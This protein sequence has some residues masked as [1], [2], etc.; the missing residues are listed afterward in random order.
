MNQMQVR[1]E[2]IKTNTHLL[3]FYA[4]ASCKKCRGRGVNEF[5]VSRGKQVHNYVLL[6]D[7]VIKA[8][9]REVNELQ[10]G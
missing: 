8:V 4:K 9:R 3:Q 6:C 1:L 10:N 5:S 7:C 2:D